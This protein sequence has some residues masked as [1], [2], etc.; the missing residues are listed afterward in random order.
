ML[1][2]SEGTVPERAEWSERRVSPGKAR[3]V[4]EARDRQ[5]QGVLGGTMSLL[6]METRG[7]DL[8]S[9]LV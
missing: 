6:S 9:D 7:G 4:M 2:R 1:Q 5:L 8:R 3:P